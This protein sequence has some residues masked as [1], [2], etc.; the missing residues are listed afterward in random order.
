LVA[1]CHYLSLVE[2][3]VHAVA[4]RWMGHTAVH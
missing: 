2:L 1:V 3:T 4:H